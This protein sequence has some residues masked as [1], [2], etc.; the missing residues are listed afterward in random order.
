M[1]TP[2]VA[3]TTQPECVT[4]TQYGVGSKVVCGAKHEPKETGL[5]DI[6]PIVL[7]SMFFVA[8]GYGLSKHNKLVRSEVGL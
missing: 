8:A 5:A 1:A 7:A 2:V 3:D 6:N 4:V